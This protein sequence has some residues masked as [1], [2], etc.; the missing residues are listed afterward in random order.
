M[1]TAK[2]CTLGA[3]L[4]VLLVG[5]APA[6]LYWNGQTCGF[7]GGESDFWDLAAANWSTN[8]AGAG[9]RQ[10]WTSPNSAVFGGAG[11]TLWL[12]A[13]SGSVAVSNLTFNANGYAIQSIAGL[14]LDLV[15][16]PSIVTVAQSNHTATIHARR[17]GGSGAAA[18]R[19]LKRGAGTLILENLEDNDDK[20]GP[21]TVEAGTL[22]INGGAFNGT[23]N[24]T[25]TVT[26]LA[27]ALLQTGGNAFGTT[28]PDAPSVALQ[29][30][31]WQLLG[32]NLL[33]H[34]LLAS[35]TNASQSEVFGTVGEVR[36]RG[37]LTNANSP[38]TVEVD[39]PVVLYDNFKFFHV[40]N[41]PA[42]VDLQFHQR[43]S[44]SGTR[45]F[46]KTGPGTLLC[47]G[48][49]NYLG[50][51]VVHAGLLQIGNGVSGAAAGDF[52][53]HASL[54]FNSPASFAIG[55]LAGAGNVA[56]VGTGALTIT[57]SAAGF[58][59][60]LTIGAGSKAFVN[61]ALGPDS[62]VI[63]SN[64]ATL[65]GSGS[66]GYVTTRSGATIEAGDG[67][68]SGSFSA[69]LLSLVGGSAV[70]LS[71]AT[72]SRVQVTTAHNLLATTPVTLN[73]AGP[74]PAAGVY[75]LINYSGSIGGNGFSAFQLGTLPNPRTLATLTNSGS[76]VQLIVSGVDFVYWTGASSGLWNLTGTTNWKLNATGTPTT[77]LENDVVQFDDRAVAKTVILAGALSP[78]QTTV[79]GTN[80]FAFTGAGGLV[81]PGDLIKDGPGS[82]TLS[83]ANTL[84][85]QV[86]VN[87][88]LLRVANPDAL[89]VP[90]NATLVQ[91][92]ASLELA[93][94]ITL[95]NEAVRLAGAGLGGSG[96]LRNG[97]GTN[98]L[99]LP[100]L[101]TS[102]A[103][104][105]CVDG[106]LVLDTTVTNQG[107]DLTLH[108]ANPATLNLARSHVGAG[109]LIKTG[110]A[111]LTLSGGGSLYGAGNNFG[112]VEV[113]QGTLI[114]NRGEYGDS[115]LGAG[116]ILRPGTVAVLNEPMFVGWGGPRSTMVL[117]GGTAL[118]NAE[119]FITTLTLSG[120][121]IGSTN[122]ADIRGA[123]TVNALANV[124]PSCIDAPLTVNTFILNVE[125][126]AAPVDLILGRSHAAPLVKNGPGTVAFLGS[127]LAGDVTINDGAFLADGVLGLPTTAVTVHGGVLGGNGL[128]LSPITIEPAATLSPGASIG[129][130]TISNDLVL[131]GTT[132]I[133]LHKAAFT[134]DAVVGV[135]NLTYGG[136]LIIT[137]LGGKL[138]PGET[139]RLFQ[140]ASYQEAFATITAP[141]LPA[142]QGWD[143]SLLPV[144]GSIMVT[145]LAIPE[146]TQFAALGGGEFQL[147]FTGT[148][149]RPCR[150]L[151][152][153]DPGL[154]VA[155]WTVLFQ[156]P[157]PRSPFTFTDAEAPHH[158]RRFYLVTQP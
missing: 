113:Q 55:R 128:V 18:A 149:G 32:T 119:G 63:V 138:A 142:S 102:N 100:L 9:T 129:T 147:T 45:G 106:E 46:A 81:G 6:D 94:G 71:P 137:N 15:G 34:L 16:N 153:E 83:N 39:R 156:G 145:G 78:S 91:A 114:V 135:S 107:W 86:R 36:L 82:L 59:G 64:G 158:P 54:L 61:G 157:L 56:Q 52:T 66:I 115:A 74:V 77:F 20:A 95:S 10:L 48:T 151:A 2:R 110:L 120:G 101:L 68:L 125:N 7:Y 148:V 24:E 108:C 35:T 90:T 116:V 136:A 22:R 93:G 38:Q 72:G 13:E 154:P 21:I 57:G 31:R 85:G 14:F 44:Q 88:G 23:F 76:A 144:D 126:G 5:A 27:G 47:L 150:I 75:D 30:G 8:A 121:W 122:G 155:D 29:G 92:G 139:F 111:P 140:A 143:F 118:M 11:G 84:A 12:V 43:I 65:G 105:A 33:R 152:S 141:P 69:G 51:T 73:I 80:A 98:A 103:L 79:L 50:G 123:C 117:Q 132:F 130:L 40:E 37:N 104:I 67:N 53:N 99:S 58:S 17:G 60:T 62:A 97:A 146:F 3:G 70:R 109:R 19:M 112:G 89:G 131:Q 42:A 87:A 26:V 96:A 1:H 28:S 49:N 124:A 4:A 127:T 134:N 41:G 25:N 133:E